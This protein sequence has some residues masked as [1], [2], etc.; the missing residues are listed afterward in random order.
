MDLP[1]KYAS[2]IDDIDG[3]GTG[4]T[5][6]GFHKTTSERS[7]TTWRFPNWTDSQNFLSQQ[8]RTPFLV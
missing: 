1:G 7:T 6:P 2:H 3:M 4:C 5:N 8:K